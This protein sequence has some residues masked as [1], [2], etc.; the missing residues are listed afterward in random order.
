MSELVYQPYASVEGAVVSLTA[1]ADKSSGSAFLAL[2]PGSNRYLLAEWAGVGPDGPDE[3]TVINLYLAAAGEEDKRLAYSLRG[4]SIQSA[5]ISPDGRYVVV[6]A[7]E[8]FAWA[9][10]S[11]PATTTMLVDLA[12]GGRAHLLATGLASANAFYESHEDLASAFVRQG[13]FAGKVL[14]AR[15]ITGSTRGL[16]DGD[17]TTIQLI[18]PERVI[19]GDRPDSVLAEARVESNGA[20]FWR[21]LEQN[22][23]GVVLL[24]RDAEWYSGEYGTGELVVLPAGKPAETHKVSI[25]PFGDIQAATATG[26]HVIWAD[27][28]RE[29]EGLRLHAFSVYRSPRANEGGIEPATEQLLTK[30]DAR[31]VDRTQWSV[32]KVNLG[33]KLFAYAL[34]GDLRAVAYD[35]NSDLILERGVSAIIEDVG[36]DYFAGLLR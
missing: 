26:Y 18:D 33:E 2:D 29:G 9:S 35:G 5:H 12:E 36:F 8:Q 24:G 10:Q 14:F 27:T 17:V 16:S 22:E 6:H 20:Y 30:R 15:H 21:V 4:G 34:G 1:A 32:R 23:D 7:H 13:V 31:A 25:P 3:N 11:Y 28:G 19:S